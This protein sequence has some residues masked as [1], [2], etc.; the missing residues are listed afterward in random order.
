MCERA[1]DGLIIQTHTDRVTRY[2]DLYRPLAA[3]TSLRFHI[4]IE[5]DRDRLPGLPPPASSVARRLEAAAALR[6]AGLRVVI[7][8]SPLLP[9]AEPRRFFERVAEVAD[10]VVVDHFIE[11]DGTPG[12]ART[13]AT[14]LP[15][16]MAR[17]EPASVRLD[18]RDRM[19]GGRVELRPGRLGACTAAFA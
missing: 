15:E 11:G 7:T 3:A 18:Y 19:L 9:I 4:S 17:V 10:A 8:V 14:P 12:G 5:C 1:P 16:A 6:A 2:L 13:L